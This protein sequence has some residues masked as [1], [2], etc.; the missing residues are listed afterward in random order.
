L[1][2]IDRKRSGLIEVQRL[3]YEKLSDTRTGWL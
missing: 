3:N 1:D 2:R